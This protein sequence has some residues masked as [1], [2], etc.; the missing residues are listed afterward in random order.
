MSLAKGAS[1]DYTISVLRTIANL[2][3]TGYR[4]RQTCHSWIFEST[5][6][7]KLGT[8]PPFSSFKTVVRSLKSSRFEENHSHDERSRAI[9]GIH[10]CSGVCEAGFR[11]SRD[12]YCRCPPSSSHDWLCFVQVPWISGATLDIYLAESVSRSTCLG[13]LV[14]VVCRSHGPASLLALSNYGSTSIQRRVFIP[15]G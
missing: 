10:L 9:F 1:N 14:Q 15:A 6:S 13:S 4:Y 8:V 3:S 7:G 12:R 11:M 2:P 5:A